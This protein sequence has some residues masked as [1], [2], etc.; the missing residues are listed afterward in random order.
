MHFGVCGGP[1]LARLAREAGYDYWEWSVPGLL[2]PL[3]NDAAFEA[4]RGQARETGLPCPVLNLF[5]PNSLPITGPQADTD[6]LRAYV[7]TA[8]VRAR[9]AGVEQIVFGSGGARRV[10]DGFDPET[11]RQQIA[12]FL[13]IAAPLAT[14]QG[15]TVLI[16]PLN[17]KDCNILTSVRESAALMDEVN[18][19]AI[20]LLADSYH[21]LLSD[22]DTDTLRARGRQIGHTH[23]ATRDNRLPPGAEPC[24]LAPFF[25]ALVQGGYNGRMSFEGKLPEPRLRHLADALV[26]MKRLAQ[27]AR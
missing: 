26:L 25:R 27:E 22:N 11:A 19:P 3:E 4:A 20:R 16:E 6:R 12:A 7:E 2:K 5:V 10:P 14:A 15:V 1:D 23:V 24:D 21:F 17:R 13:R 8:F 9:K 18:H